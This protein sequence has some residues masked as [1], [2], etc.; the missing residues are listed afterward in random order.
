MTLGA[1]MDIQA[2]TVYPL[3]PVGSSGELTSPM[4]FNIGQID[5]LVFVRLNELWHSR[6]P[7]TTNCFEGICY[8]AEFGNL[9]YAV[10]WWSKP[11]AE[12]RLKDGKKCYE[13]RRMAISDDAPRNTASR[14]LS[15]MRKDIKKRMPNIKRLISYQDTG[16]H[17]GT[18]YKASGWTPATDASFVS[19]EN[20]QD[21]NRKDQ[22]KSPKIRWEIET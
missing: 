3:F 15:I 19:W 9:Y 11:I 18:I 2:R 7:I 6:L 14:M 22:S 21:F 8:G 1:D 12:N 5:R 10:A 20:R 17:L 13:L 4:Q 16:V